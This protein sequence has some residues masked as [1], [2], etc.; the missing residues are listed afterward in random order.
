[1][2]N[3]ARPARDDRIDSEPHGV[4]RFEDPFPASVHPRFQTIKLAKHLIEDK[5]QSGAAIILV[6]LESGQEQSPKLTRRR[7]VFQRCRAEQ[8]CRYAL[9]IRRE[10]DLAAQFPR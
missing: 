7:I 4:E 6:F 10:P 5:P 9:A 8:G 3:V 1:M 2:A